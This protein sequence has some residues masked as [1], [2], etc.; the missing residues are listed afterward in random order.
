MH[1][2]AFVFGFYDFFQRGG[3][4]LARLEGTPDAPHVLPCATRTAKC[5]PFRGGDGV[6]IFS[7]R[8]SIFHATSMLLDHFAGRRAC[9]VHGD[10]AATDHDN[11]FPD[12]E[13]VAEIHVEQKVHAFVDPV[14]IDS[15]NA[16]IAAAVRAHGDEDRIESQPRRSEMT[17]FLPAA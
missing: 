11:F 3:H 1:D 17:K 7:G 15:G 9:Y 5:R 13:L 16:E 10:I 12:G 14:E 4:L 8:L 6:H 2:D